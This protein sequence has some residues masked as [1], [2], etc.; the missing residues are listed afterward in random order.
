[1]TTASWDPHARLGAAKEP[2][3]QGLP[4]VRGAG[5]ERWL[6]RSG[7]SLRIWMNLSGDLRGN[8]H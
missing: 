4:R 1:M 5:V 2:A 7:T 8:R 6:K 3:E